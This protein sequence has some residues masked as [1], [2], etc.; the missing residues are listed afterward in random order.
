MDDISGLTLS[1]LY[2]IAETLRTR[3]I[4]AGFVQPAFNRFQP[5]IFNRTPAETKRKKRRNYYVIHSK[6]P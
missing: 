6:S 5:L 3:D 1:G 4:K 2:P